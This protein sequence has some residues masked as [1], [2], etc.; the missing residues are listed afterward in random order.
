MLCGVNIAMSNTAG[1]IVYR[2]VV[3]TFMQSYFLHPTTHTL[4]LIRNNTE[5]GWLKDPGPEKTLKSPNKLQ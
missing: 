3:T 5:H 4:A 1:F 2:I